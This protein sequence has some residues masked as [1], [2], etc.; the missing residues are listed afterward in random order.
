MIAHPLI[1]IADIGDAAAVG[2]DDGRLIRAATIGQG[3]QGA[4]ADVQ[5]IDFAVGGF[6]LPVGAAIGAEVEGGG[7]G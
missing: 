3:R 5:G 2:R 7:I 4:G 1:V 6:A